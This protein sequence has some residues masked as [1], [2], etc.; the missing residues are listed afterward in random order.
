MLIC[1]RVSGGGDCNILSRIFSRLNFT[2][3]QLTIFEILQDSWNYSDKKVMIGLSGGIN[4]A[5]VLAYLA[6]NVI[7][8]PKEL[9]LFYAH[10]DEHS[11]DTIDFAHS[12]LDDA[13]TLYTVLFF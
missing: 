7:D 1:D 5:A 4:S 10:F 13:A 2:K 12:G 3:M 9:F 11:S 6:K 8:K